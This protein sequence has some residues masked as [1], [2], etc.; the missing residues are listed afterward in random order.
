M[1]YIGWTEDNEWLQYTV[2]VDS[3]ASYSL[4]F[5]Y[6]TPN[7]VSKIK[8]L[9]NNS[10]MAGALSLLVTGGYFAWNN[11]AVN[12]L[13]LYKGRQ[14]IRILFE[15]G[16]ANFNYLDFV[17]EKKTEDVPLKAVSAE[18]FGNEGLIY[19]SFNKSLNESTVTA[20]GFNCTV[21]GGV[22]D[23]ASLKINTENPYQIILS[24]SQPIFDIDDIRLNYSGGLVS[25][26]D[27]TLLQDFSNL[28]VKNNL[29]VFT[30][31]P[32]KI[33]AEAFSV[34]QGLQLETTTD[35]GGGQNIGYTNTGDYLE[36]RV[37]VLKSAKYTIEVRAACFN[38]AG[39][40]EV[41]QINPS[42]TVINSVQINIP[43]TGG[44][45]TWQTVT[46][47]IN[48]TAGIC[49]LKVKILQPEFNLNWYKFTE[50][51]TGIPENAS[52]VF[53]I[54]P[55]P[56]NDVVSILIPG[57][58]GEKKAFAIR[59]STGILMK[60]IEA[61]TGDESKRMF[62]GDLPNGLYIIEMEMDEHIYRNKL[63]I[64]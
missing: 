24:L 63:I 52:S 12:N 28:Q 54:F 32:G 56:A 18:T 64:Q 42:G 46:S 20:S 58:T 38:A 10:D 61:A 62:V 14:K 8:I 47:T 44:W 5:R 33:E 37:R 19:L 15:K 36:Y 59:S 49:T 39:K 21:N 3:T 17:L 4:K 55:N 25:A 45:Q 51:T 57:S 35:V 43:V 29:S 11:L 53:S 2:D 7:T 6:A 41:Q 40:I 31:V 16:G 1:D 23:I 22:A 9:V 60:K 48:L 30:T 34:N 27:G 13:I 50:N 26:T